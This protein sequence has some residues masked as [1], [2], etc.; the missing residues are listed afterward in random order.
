M[1]NEWINGG[2]TDEWTGDKQIDIRV[3]RWMNG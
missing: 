1:A 3:D 2:W